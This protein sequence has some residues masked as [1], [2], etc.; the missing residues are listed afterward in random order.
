MPAP[1]RSRSAR[2]G[3]RS[4]SEQ[5]AE[6]EETIEISEAVTDDGSVDDAP[7]ILPERSRG[8]RMGAALC[9]PALDVLGLLEAA[10][11]CFRLPNSELFGVRAVTSTSSPPAIPIYPSRTRSKC[12][13]RKPPRDVQCHDP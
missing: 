6:S 5:P 8:N 12:I 1:G 4:N 3:S 2:S 11:R 7:V 13:I 10:G 9:Y